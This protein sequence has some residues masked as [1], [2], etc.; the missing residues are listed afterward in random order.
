MSKA[1]RAV[2][3]TEEILCARYFVVTVVRL[4]LLTPNF[5]KKLFIYAHK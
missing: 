1:L 4:L 2:P 3:G 5:L